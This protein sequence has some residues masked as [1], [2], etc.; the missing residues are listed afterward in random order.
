MHDSHHKQIINLWV[1]HA[2][3]KETLTKWVFDYKLQGDLS[4]ASMSKTI[5][6]FYNKNNQNKSMIYKLKQIKGMKIM[7]NLPKWLS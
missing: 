6:H 7:A 5:L 4:L 2:I 1:Y 3:R